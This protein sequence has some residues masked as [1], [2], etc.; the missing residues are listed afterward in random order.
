MK[1]ATL[2]L[3]LSVLLYSCSDYVYDTNEPMVWFLN[4]VEGD[5]LDSG[6]PLIV[7]IKTSD[8]V[9][10]DSFEFMFY[11]PI[12]HNYSIDTTI[13]SSLYGEL[14]NINVNTVI[15]FSAKV[16]D[17]VLTAVC[18]DKRGRVSAEASVTIFVKNNL[19]DQAPVISLNKDTIRT[20]SGTSNFA[21]L[22]SISDNNEIT[23]VSFEVMQ[24]NGGSSLQQ[25]S[26]D[27]Y[28]D[29]FEILEFLSTP[30]SGSY[31]VYVRAYDNVL[32]L[33]EEKVVLIVN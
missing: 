1:F 19:D 32:N 21:I 4:P 33:S 2:I 25:V 14:A 24:P 22:G 23:N 3:L 11:G 18:Y 8:D 15:P 26:Y 20:F 10:L 12:G 7:E 29:A 17:Y 9:F 6:D 28:A 31:D 30:G 27:V 13:S 16:G 5:T